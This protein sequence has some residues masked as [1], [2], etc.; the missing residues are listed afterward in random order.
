VNVAH[1]HGYVDLGEVRLHY[2]EAGSGPMV[3]CHHGFPSCWLSFRFQMEALAADYRVVSVDGLGANLSS[4]PADLS[5]YR[6][7]RL[8]EQLDQ[9]TTQLGGGEPFSLVGHDWGAALAWAYAQAHPERLHGVVAIGAPPYNQLIELLRSND[10]QRLRSA[11]M[12]TMRD[13]KQHRSMTRHHG[14]DLWDHIYA[15]LRSLPHFDDAMD[16]QFRDALAVPGAVD[17]G[18]DWYRANIPTL[19]AIES[20]EAWPS[21]T[22]RARVPGLQIWGD[23]DQTFVPE[24]IDALPDYVDDL[25]VL[26]LRDTGH[27]PMIERPDDVNGAIGDFLARTVTSSGSV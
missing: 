12:W 9:L 27:W 20:F 15:P 6:V 19:D 5:L 18:I 11:Y 17:G 4:K 14:R 21:R 23:D 1:T 3:L 13:G 22:A 8:V 7:E 24:F 2:V 26:L 16:L 25:S 10:E